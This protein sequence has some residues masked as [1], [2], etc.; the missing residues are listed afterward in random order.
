MLPTYNNKHAKLIFSSQCTNYQYF[1]NT[2][3]QHTKN[4]TTDL[5]RVLAA[6]TISSVDKLEFLNTEHNPTNLFRN[7]RSKLV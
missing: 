4:K 2:Y 7:A 1:K 6:E 3:P 5:K